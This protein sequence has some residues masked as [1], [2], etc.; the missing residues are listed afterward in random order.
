MRTQLV[1]LVAHARFHL[2]V[3]VL[4]LTVAVTLAAPA[5]KPWPVDAGGV[6]Q[7]NKVCTAQA[8]SPGANGCCTYTPNTCFPVAGSTDINITPGNT[9][10]YFQTD[11]WRAWG[12]CETPLSGGGI[13]LRCMNYP[14]FTCALIRYYDD[15][16][17]VAGNCNI[18]RTDFW[19]RVGPNCCN[20]FDPANSDTEPVPVEPVPGE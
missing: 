8:G 15:N 3:G 6:L 13:N 1:D 20:P 19:V 16:P 10:A 5:Q 2:S 9:G 7:A 17:Q 4:L 11:Q 12:Y 18:P 14:Q